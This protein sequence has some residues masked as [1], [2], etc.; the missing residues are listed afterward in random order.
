M[1]YHLFY[2]LMGEETF[3]RIFKYISFRTAMATLTALLITFI[4]SPWFIKVLKSRQYGQTIRDDGP[5]THLKKQGTP[6]MGG[7]IILLSFVLSTLLWA[8][9]DTA[10][11][12]MAVGVS[13]FFGL[14]G[15]ID[16]YM[17]VAKKNTAG[18]SGKIRIVIEFI[19]GFV[20]MYVFLTQTNLGTDLSIPFVWE[21]I[22]SLPAWFYIPFGAFVLV[23]TANAV[24]LTD[25]A[26]GLAVG[27]VMTTAVVYAIFAYMAGNVVFSGY[28]NV[29]Y[30]V[31]A[32]ELTVFCGAIFGSCL[33]FLW[34]NTHPA[35]VFMGDVGSLS[36][37]S[38]LGVVAVATKNELMLLVVG[39]IFAM[40]TISVIIQVASFKLTGK[41]VFRM[42]PYHHSL[43]LRGWAE[44]K[45]V[46]RLWIISII[47]ALIG[48][49]GLKMKF[50]I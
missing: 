32:G 31:S 10:F 48:L 29:P 47:L 2:E 42:A 23:G 16:D 9:L 33:A 21:P 40:E 22:S 13:C 41:R 18:L 27:P 26:D 17:K 43:E 5:Q 20:M 35:S 11:V 50:N 49:A 3:L 12:W 28:L 14:I 38:A 30:V 8:R 44:Q 36:L 7:G 39:G 34:Y 37:G 6:T 1:F 45:M 25:G 24:N 15:F 46:V 19:I 4:F